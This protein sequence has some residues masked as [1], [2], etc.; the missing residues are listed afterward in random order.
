QLVTERKFI[1]DDFLPLLIQ[2]TEL[3]VEV[4]DNVEN[5]RGERFT[6]TL[7]GLTRALTFADDFVASGG[8]L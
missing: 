5:S 4:L 1:R 8:K 7:L 6:A 3:G 2:G